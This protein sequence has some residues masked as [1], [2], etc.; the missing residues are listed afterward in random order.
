MEAGLINHGRLLTS[1]F[2]KK[3]AAEYMHYVNFGETW[4]MEL[5]STKIPL[6][7]PVKHTTAQQPLENNV[8]LEVSFGQEKDPSDILRPVGPKLC[9]MGW[10]CL[11]FFAWGRMCS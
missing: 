2:V 1:V 6:P 7:F 9:T 8:L 5:I 10:L 4:G 3:T 11:F